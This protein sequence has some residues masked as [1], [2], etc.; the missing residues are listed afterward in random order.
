VNGIER[1][2]MMGIYRALFPTNVPVDFV[3]ISYLSQKVLGGYKLVL[4]PYPLMIPSES[5]APLRE[6]V[7]NGGCLV[8][9]ARLG[10]NNEHGL[11]SPTIPGL[12]LYEVMG[13][14]ETAVQIGAKGRTRLRWRSTALAGMKPGDE[15]TAR[16]Y[17]ETL[18]P[19]GPEAQ[20]MAEFPSGGAAAVLSSYGKGKTLTLGSYLGAAYETLREPTTAQFYEALLD[21]AGVERPVLLAPAREGIEVRWLESGHDVLVFAFNHQPKSQDAQIGLRL[22]ERAYLGTDIVNGR[23]VSTSSQNGRVAMREQIAAHDV[24]VV[25]LEPAPQ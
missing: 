24:W 21:W 11:A 6:Y 17:E 19:L 14:R 2:S 8:A 18:A 13:C 12:G 22:P 1:D 10:W 25:K 9:E 16:W 5:T 4:L 20:I 3:H 7:K 15:M 23:Q